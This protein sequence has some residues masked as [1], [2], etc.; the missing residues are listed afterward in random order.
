MFKKT[1]AESDRISPTKAALHHTILRAHYQLMVW[2]NDRAPN[3]VLPSPRGYG[4]TMENDKWLPVMTTLST[5]P[6]AIIQLVKC[7]CVKE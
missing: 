5:A 1:Q 4:L 6:E 2:I 3:L 7:K